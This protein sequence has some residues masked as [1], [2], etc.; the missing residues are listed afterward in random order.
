MQALARMLMTTWSMSAMRDVMLRDWS[1]A[2]VSTP[3]LV[4]LG[5]SLMCFLIGL[6]LF[7]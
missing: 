7:G 6:R 1:L 3:L 2:G 5:Y 4:L